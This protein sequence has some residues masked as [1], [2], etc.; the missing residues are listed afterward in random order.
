MSDVDADRLRDS[1]S[2]LTARS[3]RQPASAV[4]RPSVRATLERDTAVLTTFRQYGTDWRLRV[5]EATERGGHESGPS[6]M[7]Y[8]LTSVAGCLLGWS[9]KTWAAAHVPLAEIEL[10]VRTA[11]D[12]R[13]EH[14]V[15]DTPAYPPWFVADLRVHSEAAPDQAIDL[16]R[17]ARDRCPV[18]ALVTRAVPLYLLL[19]HEGAIVLD[20]RPDRLSAEDREESTT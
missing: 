6:P 15:D 17:E 11:L 18:T 9:A 20:E 12:L 8:L 1:L 16:A 4:M 2:T 7:R 14:R 13:G 19:H 3:L 5:D 10:E